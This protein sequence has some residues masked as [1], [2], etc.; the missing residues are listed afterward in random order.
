MADQLGAMWSMPDVGGG[1]DGLLV[2]VRDSMVAL[3]VHIMV[4]PAGMAVDG[5]WVGVLEGVVVLSGKK[6]LEEAA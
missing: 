5:G 1:E 3:S 6:R 2:V 4:A